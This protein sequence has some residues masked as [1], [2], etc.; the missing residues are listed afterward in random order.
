MTK[1]HSSQARNSLCKYTELTRGRGEGREAKEVAVTCADHC[2]FTSPVSLATPP[3][4][5]SSSDPITVQMGAEG[6]QRFREVR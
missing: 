6:V 4:P 5:R 2:T 3:P 1:L